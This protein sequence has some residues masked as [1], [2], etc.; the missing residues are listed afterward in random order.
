LGGPT[1]LGTSTTLIT[2]LRGHDGVVASP[3][4]CE[5][6]PVSVLAGAAPAANHEL[7]NVV[8]ALLPSGQQPAP[9]DLLQ[10]T[11]DQPSGLDSQLAAS[12]LDRFVTGPTGLGTSAVQLL[13]ASTAAATSMPPSE[14]SLE[15]ELSCPPAVRDGRAL[16][17]EVNA[18]LMDW[19]EQVGIYPGRADRLHKA[20]IGRLVMLAHSASGRHLG[21]AR[22]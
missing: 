16:G 1:G 8:A 7:A 9:K 18:R 10:P 17:E 6:A 13:R 20:N 12:L 19:T 4:P 2:G 15:R 14:K 21:L 5:G 3:A 22:W 11:A